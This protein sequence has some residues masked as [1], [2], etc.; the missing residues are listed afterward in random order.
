MTNGYALVQTEKD[1]VQIVGT[2]QNSRT[3]GLP[4]ISDPKEVPKGE[5]VISYMFK[6]R[7]LD[8]TYLQQVLGQYLSPPRPYT[9]FLALPDARAVMVIERTSVIRP[10]VAMVLELDVPPLPPPARPPKEKDTP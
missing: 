3:V 6:L 9:S 4:I 2:G 10:L 5:R 1:I 7:H 8:P